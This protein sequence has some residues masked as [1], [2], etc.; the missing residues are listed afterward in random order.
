MTLVT[1]ST[2]AHMPAAGA[3]I[4]RDYEFAELMS[5]L[6]D[7]RT[8]RGRLFLLTG[9]A[10]IGK[11]RLLE[12]LADA[13][14]PTDTTVLWGR[15]WEGGGAAPYWPWS[16]VLHA[17][18]RDLDALGSSPY[19]DAVLRY[20]SKLVD[21]RA[22]GADSVRASSAADLPGA[23]AALFDAVVTF[24]RIRSSEGGLVVALEDLHAADEASLRLL[25]VVVRELSSSPVLIVGTYRDA[26]VR[27]SPSLHQLMSAISR[28]G[29][30]I[31]LS[32]LD[33]D[34]VGL[35]VE[36]TTGGARVGAD[37]RLIHDTTD[38]N[39]FFVQEV[40]RLLV[41]EH[42]IARHVV[43][44]GRVPVPEEVHALIRRRLD[45]LPAEA[46][47][48]LRVASVLGRHFEV[49][50]VAALSDRSPEAL[51][52]VLDRGAELG[53]VEDRA[54]G[55]WQFSHALLREALYDDM[56]PSQRVGL[57][58]RAGEAIERLAGDDV[59]SRASELAHHFF[60]A[61]RG[62]EG[63]R[64]VRYCSIAARQAA[65]AMAF[66]EAALLYGRALEALALSRPVEELTRYE[67]LMGLAQAQQR[68][69]D[70]T[71]ARETFMRAVKAAR[72]LASP[73]LLARAAIAYTGFIEN[74]ADD[75]RTSVLEEALAVLPPEDSAL[76]A[77]ILV[78]LANR[79]KSARF[80]S[81]EASARNWERGWQLAT[82]GIEMARRVADPENR[83]SALWDWHF[84]A[85]PHR[86]TLDE[87]LRV[88]DDLI[89][90]AVASGNPE[91]LVLARQWRAGDYFA[92][93]DIPAF[94][95][96]VEAARREADELRMPFLLWGVVM[97][98]AGLALLRGD[99]D[100]GE[101]FAREALRHGERAEFAD[102][103]NTFAQQMGELHQHRAEFPELERVLR[104]FIDRH[105]LRGK[106]DCRWMA[107]GRIAF[108]TGRPDEALAIYRD[109]LPGF[110]PEQFV[111]AKARLCCPTSLAQLAWLVQADEGTDRIRELL[112]P[113]AGTHV[114]FGIGH[115]SLGACDRYLAQVAALQGRFDEAEEYF[116]SA[117]EL[118]VRMETP[119]WEAYT[120]A[121]HAQMLLRR[122]RAAD[123]ER[124]G[125]LA[126]AAAVR[127]A[128]L[129]MRFWEGSARS[130]LAGQPA[131]TPGPSRPTA[132]DR[133]LLR[134]EGEYWA[135]H[136]EGHVAR[137]RDSKGLRYLARLLRNPAQ[138]VHA[139]DLVVGDGGA[140]GAS[141]RAPERELSRTGA[142]DAGA[143]LDPQAKAA[144]RRRLEDLRDEL[145]EATYNNDVGRAARA[146]EE[147]DFLLAELSAAVGLGG[148]DRKA[149]SDAE[150]ARQS[151]TRA[152]KAA[153]ERLGEAHAPL[154]EHLRSTVR[155]GIYSSYV[156][157]P[158]SPITWE[159]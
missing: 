11:T 2:A 30:R 152:I 53:V 159:D 134:Q 32:G 17:V 92:A 21:E 57:H 50:V 12:A 85:M 143:V 90:L 135:F 116:R 81:P 131:V 114:F 62:G 38:G 139:L 22:V 120:L 129:G 7:L 105:G 48:A 112:L 31:A 41:A 52:D 42:Q 123:R 5:A 39:P 54:L 101:R 47:E 107:L 9:D 6:D 97:M 145:D 49:G 91:R 102:V 128:G 156:P 117:R 35:L 15:C 138:E 96:E 51:L 125:E 151:V 18:L 74:K 146:Q 130:L 61:A 94:A 29:R 27:S 141:G 68:A 93:G 44:A 154:G 14:E 33:E 19:P 34:G 84:S 36:R 64:A 13:A 133:A 60:E 147:M 46:F 20:V 89:E 73:E 77:R 65:A 119:L 56:R 8:G 58:R 103:E 3:L 24:L 155:T 63:V 80:A 111:R 99:L 72:A 113:H 144:Y 45:R 23:R 25:Q 100:E 115:N 55:R 98:Q 76:R 122:G 75:S 79:V 109:Q 87:R 43:A 37:T 69:G 40:A 59:D 126:E 82:E 26:E 118:N 137:L 1:A 78:L 108:L 110:A 127:F 148:R 88:A 95:A 150:R 67:L 142:G 132:L 136:Y 83:W 106:T 104:E 71:L 157:D 16:Q 66:E 140:G 70:L 10:G 158:R 149:A 28:Q 121:D 153:I 86:E 4:G 124:A